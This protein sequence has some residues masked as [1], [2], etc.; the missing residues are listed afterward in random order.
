[1]KLRWGLRRRGTGS[2]TVLAIACATGIASLSGCWEVAVPLTGVVAFSAGATVVSAN[3]VPQASPS[4]SLA[5]QSDGRIPQAVARSTKPL[6]TVDL[7][8]PAHRA[9]FPATS[10]VMVG[11]NSPRQEINGPEAG[12]ARHGID[13]SPK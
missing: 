12:T 1:M 7:P 10:I 3:S 6:V 4:P 5:H 9:N 13:V 2:P 8:V 11:D